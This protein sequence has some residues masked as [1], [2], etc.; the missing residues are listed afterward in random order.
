MA[1]AMELSVRYML[2][3]LVLEIRV[4]LATHQVASYHKSVENVG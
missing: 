2:R 3:E 1:N 4:K